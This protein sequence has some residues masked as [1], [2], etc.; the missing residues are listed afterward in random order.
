MWNQCFIV[1]Y[2]VA[3]GWLLEDYH[4]TVSI[5]KH[6]LYNDCIEV[7]SSRI[8]VK[9]LYRDDYL[10]RAYDDRTDI[11]C[12]CNRLLEEIKTTSTTAEMDEQTKLKV[13]EDILVM[14]VQ[15]NNHDLSKTE[16][17]FIKPYI[18][19][20][21]YHLC[22]CFISDKTFNFPEVSKMKFDKITNKYLIWFKGLDSQTEL[23][24][25]LITTNNFM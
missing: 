11:K 5:L 9:S 3:R 6:S 1:S 19:D 21:L 17:D 15:N 12:M 23:L 4:D 22:R 7:D 20:S 18:T 13:V 16:L 24:N 10:V 14:F 25:K 2:F 8:R